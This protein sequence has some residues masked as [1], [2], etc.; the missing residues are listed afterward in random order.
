MTTN[1][2]GSTPPGSQKGWEGATYN[3]TLALSMTAHR[4]FQKF[5]FTVR[6]LDQQKKWKL[7]WHPLDENRRDRSL[8]AALCAAAN[9]GSLDDASVGMIGAYREGSQAY[10]NARRSMPMSFAVRALLCA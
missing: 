4:Y 1:R 8:E 6:S 3:I 10:P 2:A 7:R 5:F 9:G